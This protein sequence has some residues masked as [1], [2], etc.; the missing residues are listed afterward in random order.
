M[1][2]LT[3]CNDKPTTDCKPATTPVGAAVELEGDPD[4]TTC[5]DDSTTTPGDDTTP[6]DGDVDD[7]PGAVPVEADLFGSQV[8]FTNFD[9]ADEQKVEQALEL[10]RQVVR[11]P[12]FRDRVL[13]H[14]YNGAKSFA[15]ND[16]KTNA[17]I[18]QTFID[19]EEKLNPGKNHRMDLQLELYTNNSNNVVGYTYPNVLKIWM[20]TKY[21]NQY[22]PCEVARNLFHEWS[23]KLGYGHDSASTAKRPYS[24]PYGIGSIMQ[25]LAC[26]L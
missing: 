6:D 4:P 7:V 8:S 21:F 20:N 25:D 2:S 10:I 22:E 17:Q 12:E 19:G 24:V 13:N 18:Y 9:V 15:N 16:G 26:E 23:H 14:K 11:T 1:F 5:P 3:A